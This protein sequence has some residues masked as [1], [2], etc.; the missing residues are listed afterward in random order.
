MG[1]STVS[2]SIVTPMYNEELCVEEFCRRVV[3]T[4]QSLHRSFEI[5]IISDG[6]TDGTAGIASRRSSLRRTTS[7]TRLSNTVMAMVW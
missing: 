4:L 2:I 3:T 6:S 5:I 1:H 7:L